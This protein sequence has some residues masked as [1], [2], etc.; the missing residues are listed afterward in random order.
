MKNF[1]RTM[2]VAVASALVG[3]S[4]GA[5]T[6][7]LTVKNP[8]IIN[9]SAIDPT[10]DAVTLASSA[11]QNFAAALGW[12][13]MYQSWMIGEALVAETF[14]T[15]NEYGRREVVNTNTSHNADVWGTISVAIASASQVLGLDLPEPTTNINIARAAAF[16]GYSILV[17]SDGFCTGVIAGGGELSVSQMLDSAVLAFEQAISVGTANASAAGIELAN[18][19][20]VGLARAH[21][22]AGRKAQAAAAANSV[23]AGFVFNLTYLDDP[24]QRNRLGNRLWQFTLDRGSITVAP[25][26]RIDGDPRIKYKSPAQHNL[27]PQDPSSG[28][29]FIQDK[30]PAFSTPIRLASKLEADYIAAEANGT[31][32]MLTLIAARRAA[33]NQPVYSGPTD[34]ASVLTELME[35]RGREFYLEAK[36]MGDFRRNPAAVL[37]V[38]VPGSTYF[39]PGFSPVGNQTCWPLPLAETDNNP[40]FP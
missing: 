37:N 5:C 17:M 4:L 24:A 20:R 34:D 8:N 7:F 39:K 29:F 38:P 35:Q 40:N 23:P 1:Q 9:A 3:V 28:A 11:Q 36:R 22:Q 12:H 19:A 31:A 27:A 14:P 15:R 21:L 18:L 26:F 32:A 33:N 30:F 16:K 2:R 13:A 6:D 10:A 25:A